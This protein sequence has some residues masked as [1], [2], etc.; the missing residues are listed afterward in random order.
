[1]RTA[2]ATNRARLHICSGVISRPRE[3]ALTGKCETVK[4]VNMKTADHQVTD[5]LACDRSAFC[6]TRQAAERI[7][8]SHRTVQLWVENGTLRAWRTAAAIA[9]SPSN[10]STAR[11]TDAASPWRHA[12]DAPAAPIR[13]RELGRSGAGRRRR[14]PDA[15]PVRARDLGL[16]HGAGGSPRPATAS[17]RWSA[18]A[19]SGPTCW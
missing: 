4:S 2:R 19:S 15:A 13:R 14:R 3:L 6:T 5:G 1:M 17:R 16:G 18:S 11:S 9:A 7:G 8:V 10:R 12:R